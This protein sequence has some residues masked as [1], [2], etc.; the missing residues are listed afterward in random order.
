M[1][2]LPFR[3]WMVLHHIFV[4]QLQGLILA[5][6]ILFDDLLRGDVTAAARDL[7]IAAEL[8]R[9]AAAA[10]RLAK[11]IQREQYIGEIRPQM[12]P[13]FVRSGFSGIWSADHA[14]FLQSLR[15]VGP[16]LSKT[17]TLGPALDTYY[18][19][20]SQLYGEHAD[21]CEGF[22]GSGESLHMRSEE[23]SGESAAGKLRGHFR[24]RTL[25]YAGLGG[26]K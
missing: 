7:L 17:P 8:L 4:I 16:L 13:P 5:H 14:A 20:L 9:A 19:V 3:S 25:T 21:I 11:A 26:S 22:V 6:R 1:K 18:R 2:T 24:E 15:R 12:E 10:M 23:N